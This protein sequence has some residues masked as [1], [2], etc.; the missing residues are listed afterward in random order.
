MHISKIAFTIES[1]KNKLLRA[2][3]KVVAND[4]SYCFIFFL[5]LKKSQK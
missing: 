1:E 5:I 4:Q 2:K 3:S